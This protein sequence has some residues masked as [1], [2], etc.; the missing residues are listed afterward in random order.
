M[1]RG[2]GGAQVSAPVQQ[3]AAQGAERSKEYDVVALGNLCVDV[4]V[5]YDE[6][7]S[8]PCKQGNSSPNIALHDA[9]CGT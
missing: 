1:R 2:A 9:F 3:L 6:V 5:S 7:R 4:V 8:F